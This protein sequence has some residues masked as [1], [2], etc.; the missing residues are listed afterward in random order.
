[1]FDDYYSEINMKLQQRQGGLQLGEDHY[2]S[3]IQLQ[4]KAGQAAAGGSRA[5]SESKLACGGCRWS[6]ERS[7]V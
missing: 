3:E 7:V 4:Q 1:M 2:C 6:R 5:A